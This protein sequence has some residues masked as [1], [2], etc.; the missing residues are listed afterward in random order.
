MTIDK[1]P[2][3]FGAKH[4]I[5]VEFGSDGKTHLLRRLGNSCRDSLACAGHLQQL[6]QDVLESK[7]PC[8]IRKLPSNTAIDMKFDK[9]LQIIIPIDTSWHQPDS[10][11]ARHGLN[12]KQADQR[13][14]KTH[15]MALCLCC[16]QDDNHTQQI[17]EMKYKSTLVRDIIATNL[18]HAVAYAESQRLSRYDSMT[19]LFVRRIFEERL[20]QACHESDRYGQP[21]SMALMDLDNFKEIND[22]YG[23][24][25]GDLVLEE[26]GQLIREN[27]RSCDVASRYGGDEFAIL[28]P[29]TPIE[30]AQGLIERF[31]QRLIEHT[32]AHEH[33]H[34]TI[35]IGVAAYDPQLDQDPLNLVHRADQAMYRV[36]GNGKNA[37]NSDGN[38]ALLQRND[39]G[40]GV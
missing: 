26:V 38:R 24:L 29:G 8:L 23:H 28:L 1:V 17:E 16:S 37:I 10:T 6:A 25:T 22:T 13:I 27:L 18:S 19:G 33:L 3:I 2:K 30:G 34:T 7:Q 5:L 14:Q 21:V 36:K 15:P 32:F 20:V 31:R 39:N 9:A 40:G 4:G 35:S 11:A 12:R